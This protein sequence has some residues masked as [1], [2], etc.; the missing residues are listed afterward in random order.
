MIKIS[1]PTS[2]GLFAT[3]LLASA[4]WIPFY[5]PAV[6][7]TNDAQ[8]YILAAREI[9]AGTVPWDLSTAQGIH[10]GLDIAYPNFLALVIR[11]SAVF[12]VE[13]GSILAFQWANCILWGLCAA[14]FGKI[15]R[16]VFHA[17]PSSSSHYSPGA[18]VPWLVAISPWMSSFAPRVYSEQLAF[19]F[20][21]AAVLSGGLY[22]QATGARKLGWA[23]LTVGLGT[24]LTMTKSIFFAIALGWAGILIAVSIVGLGT[25]RDAFRKRAKGLLQIAAVLLGCALLSYPSYH[26]SKDGPRAQIMLFGQL[27]KVKMFTWSEIAQC[28][29]FGFSESVGRTVFPASAGICK[30]NDKFADPRHPYQTVDTWIAEG[31]SVEWGMQELRAQPF[32]AAF[33]A[34]AQST[35]AILIEGY[36]SEPL[37]QAPGWLKGAL[38]L[39]R[40]VLCFALIG[41]SLSTFYGALKG[42]ASQAVFW[43]AVPALI[44]FGLTSAVVS[45]QRHF[46]PLLAVH[47]LL[48]LAREPRTRDTA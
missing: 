15:A 26:R 24:L 23:A 18:W 7:E 5:D 43:I 21:F 10:R 34:L 32:K 38:W 33:V 29:V 36:Y 4:F 13:P 31:R 27:A 6:I 2:F 14:L 28:S 42:R 12:G 48:L 3:G 20:L 39:M 16:R 1:R 47:W 19:T 25:K 22:A 35:N 46:M 8:A 30:H 45:E 17:S 11:L 44:F 41:A 40:L 37:R 9:A